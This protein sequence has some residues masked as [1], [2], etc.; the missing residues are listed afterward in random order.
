LLCI[1]V[2]TAGCSRSPDS[3]QKHSLQSPPTVDLS[4]IDPSLSNTISAAVQSVQSAPNS[5]AAWGK[6]G[7]AL[8]A[9][10][11]VDKAQTCYAQA[12]QLDPASGRWLYLLAVLQLQNDP[13]TALT[14]LIHSTQ[15]VASTNDAPRLRL[16][17]SFIERGQYNDAVPHLEK[18][19]ATFP[20][21][22]A[23]RLELARVKLASNEPAAAV[24]LLQPA[25]TNNYTAKS[26]LLLLSQAKQRLGDTSAASLAAR[27]NAV[28]RS[29]EWPDPF[30]REVQALLSDRQNL[31][32]RVNALIMQQRLADA[33]GLLNQLLSRDPDNPEA[34]L[35]FGRLRIQQRR[36]AEAEQILNRHLTLRT[37]SLQGFAQYGLALFCQ[38]KFSE[39]I[40]AFRSTIA[41]KPDFAQAHYNLGLAL[42]RSGNS[43]E[44]LESFRNAL[45]CQ[46]G[47]AAVQ[48]AIAEELLRL[49][50]V[51]DAIREADQALQLDPRQPKALRVKQAAA[52]SS[53]KQ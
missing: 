4:T 44:A 20:A 9:A 5:A 26:A 43:K 42:S 51:A 12:I 10:E 18:L 53:N 23:A 3:S 1:L 8:H 13:D 36:C 15:L 49:G 34:I 14:N 46:P 38:D 39:A 27:A 29:F 21:H 24:E 45:R 31:L 22:P 16:A 25:L 41:L 17:R 7:Q 48:A 37:N 28:P 32:D 6:L 33:E 52:K 50:L 47:D 40:A 11:F 30:L 35:L 2:G 19:L